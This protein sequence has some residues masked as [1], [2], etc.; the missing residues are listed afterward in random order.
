MNS[1]QIEN[2]VNDVVLKDR[3]KMASNQQFPDKIPFLKEAFKQK[4]NKDKRQISF[5]FF[6]E[7][8]FF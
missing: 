1:I 3:K 7:I 5:D 4:T 8:S 6:L 2:Q